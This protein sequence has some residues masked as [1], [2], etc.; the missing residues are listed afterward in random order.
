M[1]RIALAIIALLS[2]TEPLL[3]RPWLKNVAAAQKEAKQK[4]QLIFVDLF[5]EWCGWCHKMEQEVFPSEKFQLATKDMVLLRVD[6]EDRG[7]GS[8]LG[9]DF[10][11][12][13]LPT[14]LVLT[15]DMLVAGVLMGYAPAA[16]FAER[17]AA[18]RQ[19]YSVFEKKMNKATDFQA[20]VDVATELIVRRGFARAE[21]RLVKLLSEKGVPAAVRDE[22]YYQL[23]VSQLS[24][25]KYDAT[26]KTLKNFSAVQ[27]KGEMFV[28][29]RFLLGQLYLDQGK[30]KTALAEFRNF[31]RNYPTSPLVRDVESYVS[32]LEKLS[33]AGN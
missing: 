28:R 27:T 19:Q 14:F 25:D 22:A 23:A 12:T 13:S 30:Y 4:N 32:Q 10:N 17:L 1:K 18:V 6:T 9:S 3:A 24:Q 33:A 11:I 26:L 2:L 29:S 16:Q 31:R 21:G 15:P 20:R 8:R 7:E 5:A